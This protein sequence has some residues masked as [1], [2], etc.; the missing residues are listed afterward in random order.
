MQD[1][2][3]LGLYDY[4]ARQY[5]PATGRFTSV[6]PLADMMRRHSP[7]NYAFD[8]PI[9]FIDPDGMGPNDVI[10]TGNKSQEAL[11]ELQ[12]AVQGQLNLSMDDAGKVTA[13]RTGDGELTKGASDLLNATTDESIIVNV[14]ATDNDFVSDNSGPL[15]GAF[16]G[17]KLSGSDPEK[18]ETS[19][20][21]NPVALGKMDEINGKPGQSTL[22]EVT[23]SYAGGALSQAMGGTAGT[24]GKATPEDAA[25]RNSVY[26]QAHD[27]VV[28]QSGKI[29]E[30]FYN[31]KGNEVF[32]DTP[33]FAPVKLQYTTG[34]PSKV[35]HAVPK[36]K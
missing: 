2:L 31:A 15:L 5:D 12:K 26:R 30:H 36:S 34:R 4:I 16:M 25:N 22:H 10:I 21:I 13:T 8:N 7:Y 17:N 33:S 24:A 35:F 6:D 20:E 18:I 27:N 9:R 3:N 14:S 19:Q 11:Q 32:R 28:P 29:T 1:E 23:E